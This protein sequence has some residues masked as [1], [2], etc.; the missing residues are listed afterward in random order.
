MSIL[1]LWLPILVSAVVVFLASS[2]IWMVFKYHNKDY[3]KVNDEEAVRAALSGTKPGFYLVP[4]CM[5]PAEFKDPEGYW[6]G[7][8]QPA[9]STILPPSSTCRS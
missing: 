5:D 6:T 7:S 8:S 3:L 2:V 9:K 1:D 4:Y